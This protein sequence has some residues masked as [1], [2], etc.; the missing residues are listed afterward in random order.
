MIDK[1][2]Q[3]DIFAVR[4][5][6]LIVDDEEINRDIMSAILAD[7]F[8]VLE[9]KDGQE[10]LDILTKSE[11]VINLVLLDIFMPMDGRE[12]LKI[13]QA[14]PELKKIPFIVCTSDKDIE[15]ECFHLGVND[16]IKKPY[17]N[18]DIIVAR[19]KRMIELYEDRSILKEVE[20]DKLTN[21]F[22]REF[23]KKFARQFDTLFKDEQ[24]DM[25]SISINRFDFINELYGKEL[26][27]KILL[28]I[29]GQL[30]RYIANCN[31]L[32]GKDAGSTFMVYCVHHD[33]YDI[34]KTENIQ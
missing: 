34:L 12:V 29:A 14:N 3:N 22:N 25:L 28:A 4:Q 7:D 10:A 26:G 21:L 1:N 23:F 24:K 9:A 20:R 11:Q 30:E 13:R 8:N 19:I 2:N 15:E 33:N 32:V 16:F 17:E 27:D 5:T 18:P 31:G 6:V